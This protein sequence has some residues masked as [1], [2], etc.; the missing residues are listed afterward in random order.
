MGC[1]G[2]CGCRGGARRPRGLHPGATPAEFVPQPPCSNARAE[3]QIGPKVF[4]WL[5][6][7]DRVSGGVSRRSARMSARRSMRNRG[8]LWRRTNRE[9]AQSMAST[10]V[11]WRTSP[12]LKPTSK[13][14]TEIIEGAA[15]NERNERST[16]LVISSRPRRDPAGGSPPRRCRAASC[17][18]RSCAR[19][20]TTCPTRSRCSRRT[21]RRSSRRPPLASFSPC[22]PSSSSVPALGEPTPALARRF[23][24]RRCRRDGVRAGRRLAAALD[25]CAASTRAALAGAARRRVVERSSAA[26]RR[27]RRRRCASPTARASS[28]FLGSSLGNYDD[29]EI[30]AIFRLVRVHARRRRQRRPLR[31]RRR[32]AALAAEAGARDPR[33]LQ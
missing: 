18:R 24:R 15:A 19:P 17:T 33:S 30:G 5:R 10:A 7:R 11:R 32:H 12:T 27:S 25:A 22:R 29:A 23:D 2:W 6:C 1:G 20:S 9:G 8:C 21:R 14:P 16:L 26:S 4:G 31:R 28:L 13:S 3:P